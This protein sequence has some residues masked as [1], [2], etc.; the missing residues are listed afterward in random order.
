ME[1]IHIYIKILIQIEKCSD[2]VITESSFTVWSR[3][4]TRKKLPK[5]QA[6]IKQQQLS[7]P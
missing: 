1:R 6:N 3:E 5:P 7:S 4:L 2:F